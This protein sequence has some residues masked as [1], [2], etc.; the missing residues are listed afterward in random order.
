[1]LEF[2]CLAVADE[3][4][5]QVEVFVEANASMLVTFELSAS[6]AS[7]VGASSSSP[8]I[9]GFMIYYSTNIHAADSAYIPFAG[10]RNGSYIIYN[11]TGKDSLLLLSRFLDL[12]LLC[13]LSLN[14]HMI[15][16]SIRMLCLCLSLWLFVSL[17]G[18]TLP[19]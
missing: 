13:L 5:F 10:C 8:Y 1:M 16:L 9:T 14:F 4:P 6:M 2:C 3:A 7:M 18:F 19:H 11:E 15:I 12:S 17:Y